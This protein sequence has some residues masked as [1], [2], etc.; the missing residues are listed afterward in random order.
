MGAAPRAVVRVAPGVVIGDGCL[1][2]NHA[3][4]YEGSQL[5]DYCVV[6]D[7]VRVGYDT[8]IGRGVRLVY[9]AWVCDRVRI[10]DGARVAG[11]ICDG[12][13][14]RAGYRS[15]VGVPVSENRYEP[16]PELPDAD[17]DLSVVVAD[18]VRWSEVATAVSGVDLV[19]TRSSAA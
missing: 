14:F 12:T 8:R 11:F 16:V 1:V 3:V 17:F 6:E 13:M 9:G 18:S 19:W 4:I 5:G 10:G 15:P 7:R 2:F